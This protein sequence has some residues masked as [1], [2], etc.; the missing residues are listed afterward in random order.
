VV[1]AADRLR[2]E[3]VAIV[4]DVLLGWQVPQ[5]ELMI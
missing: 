5:V 2:S 3:Q 4:I 1:R